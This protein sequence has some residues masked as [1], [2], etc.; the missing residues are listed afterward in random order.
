M[1]S[2]SPAANAVTLA[3]IPGT[4]LYQPVLP[5]PGEN[6][7][8]LRWS[9]ASPPQQLALEDTWAETGPPANPG[10]F[11]FLNIMP[12]SADAGAVEQDLRKALPPPVHTGFVWAIYTA[13]ETPAVSVQILLS[14]KRNQA[15]APCVDGNTTFNT[16]PGAERVGFGDASP[17][18]TTLAGGSIIGFRVGYPPA[19]SAY[20][21]RGVAVALPMTGAGVG[22][23]QFAG[24]VNAFSEPAGGASAKKTLVAVSIDPLHPLDTSRNYRTFTG[25]DFILAS[26][27][28]GYRLYRAS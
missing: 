6:M 13:G 15:Q 16:L 1:K 4:N 21:P 14:V 20:T 24:L 23:A 17:V 7:L 25:Q 9:T 12:A 28:G 8:F 22:C 18:L 10:Y 19:M 5:G 27:G 2:H 11:I 3:L 26:E